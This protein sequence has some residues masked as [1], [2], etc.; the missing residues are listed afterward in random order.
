MTAGLDFS[1]AALWMAS[2]AEQSLDQIL[3]ALERA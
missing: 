3:A 1:G 2:L